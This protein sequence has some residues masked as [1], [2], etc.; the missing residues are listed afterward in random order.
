ME[1]IFTIVI[2]FV[3]PSVINKL[4]RTCK[5]LEKICHNNEIWDKFTFES[6][7]N[8]A[9][10]IYDEKVYEIDYHQWDTY[11][12]RYHKD[13]K[14]NSYEV[15]KLYCAFV[16]S[17]GYTFSF[18]NLM[19]NENLY[20]NGPKPGQIPYCPDIKYIPKEIEKLTIL[21]ELQICECNLFIIP[22]EIGKLTKLRKL[23][24][25]FNNIIIIPKEIGELTNLTFLCL[26]NNKI[27]I[28]PKEIGELNNLKE[29]YLDCNKIKCFIKVIKKLTNLNI[30]FLSEN[31][32]KT[33]PKS[34]TNLTNLEVLYISNRKDK[35]RQRLPNGFEYLT[36]LKNL[37]FK[38]FLK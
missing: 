34:I 37:K 7:G 17:F 21:Q 6:S 9:R 10:F 11:S 19:Y 14:I 15:Y 2:S 4:M 13:M 23:N 33:I 24:L 16:D 28:L 31:G 32:I 1:D 35:R 5:F 22:E 3:G 30:L 26:S 18:D 38:D 8:D 27:E 12:R 20:L 25:S 29:L 36:Q